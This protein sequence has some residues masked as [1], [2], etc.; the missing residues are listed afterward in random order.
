[1]NDKQIR[2]IMGRQIAKNGIS[3]N[4]SERVMNYRAKKVI[5]KK[6]KKSRVAISCNECK[7]EFYRMISIFTCEIQCP[8]CGGYDTEP[9]IW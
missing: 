7:S 5:P 6:G 4:L 3:E 2:E 9:T 1:M 8:Q